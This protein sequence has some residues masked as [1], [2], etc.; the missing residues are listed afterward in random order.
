MKFNFTES[1]NKCLP[2]TWKDG[3]DRK[4]HKV[5]EVIDNGFKLTAYKYWRQ[6]KKRWE[7]GIIPNW[8][9]HYSRYLDKQFKNTKNE[10]DKQSN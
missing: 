5:E 1:N 3:F 8:E 4:C 2:K 10:L 6:N 7:Y 9:F